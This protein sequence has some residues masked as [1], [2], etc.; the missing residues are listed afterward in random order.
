MRT[1]TNLVLMMMPLLAWGAPQSDATVFFT[2]FAEIA[3]NEMKRNDIPASIKLGQAA[4]ES[5]F[6]KSELAVNANNYFG[7]KCRSNKDCTSSTYMLKDD[8][9]NAEGE[10]I[11]SEFMAF[12]DPKE[13]FLMHTQF[14]KSNM[15]RYG[16]LF[17]LA[18]DDYIGWA[19]GLQEAGYATAQDY[20]ENLIKLIEKYQLYKYDQQVMNNSTSY[21]SKV[22]ALNNLASIAQPSNPV[23]E[24]TISISEQESF[25][26]ESIADYTP[27]GMNTT[28]TDSFTAPEN[29][30]ASAFAMVSHTT[31][32]NDTK[33]DMYNQNFG[34]E[35]VSDYVPESYKEIFEEETEKGASAYSKLNDLP[36]KKMIGGGSQPR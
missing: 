35:D 36:S 21:V 1:I 16:K 14:L 10:L 13:S 8:D 6:G 18:K 23:K 7:I 17:D 25:G 11:H 29:P 26:S 30:K 15:G 12:E 19:N 2:R 5:G 27:A 22:D 33:K 3:Q 4:L 34:S 28:T 20:A 9:Y 31:T 24:E 32:S